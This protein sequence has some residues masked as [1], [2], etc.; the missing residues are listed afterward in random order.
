ME[1]ADR[2]HTSWALA[3]LLAAVA[4]LL[5]M[6]YGPALWTPDAV[7]FSNAGDG[8][9]NYYTFLYHAN[10]DASWW[11]FRGMNHP[12]GEHVFFTDGHPWVSGLLR[13][14][15]KIFPGIAGHGVGILNYVLLLGILACAL[16][17][18]LLMRKFDVRPWLAAVGA[19]GITVLAPQTPRLLGHMALSYSIFLP[20]TWYVLIQVIHHKRW[21]RWALFLF[22]TQVLWWSTHAYLGAMA[23]AFG[24]LFA[25]V[26]LIIGRGSVELRSR[27][28]VALCACVLPILLFRT[29][30]SITDHHVGRSEHPSGFFQY[31]AE[32]DDILLPSNP[33]LRPVLD[34]FTDGTISTQWEA[35]AYIGIGTILVLILWVV[36]AIRRKRA[37]HP[38]QRSPIAM[39]AALWSSLILLLFAFCIPFKD[40]PG[41]LRWFPVFE[42]FRATGRFTWP[43]FFVITVC[44]MY[45]INAW[46]RQERWTGSRAVAV[47]LGLCV[48]VTWVMEGLPAHQFR[49][50]LENSPNLFSTEHA[51]AELVA[52]V[53]SQQ[54]QPYQALLPMPYFNF[55]SESFTRPS[56]DGITRA[57][58]PI[59]Y[60]LHLPI[61]GS[62]LSRVSVPESKSL[63][64]I[65]SAPWY[66]KPIADQLTRDREI[67]IVRSD[68]PLTANEAA[69][70]ALARPVDSIPGIRLYAIHPDELF[71]VRSDEVLRAFQGIRRSLVEKNGL[72]VSDSNATAILVDFEDRPS[73][74]A[75]RGSGAFT[76]NKLGVN[77]VAEIEL[78]GVRLGEEMELSAWMYN[79][80]PE[81]LNLGLRL[82]V[83]QIDPSGT[84]NHVDSTLPNEAETVDGDWSLVIM[85]FRTLSD[86]PQIHV[87]TVCLG[88]HERDLILDDLLIRVPKGS[89]YRVLEGSADDPSKLFYN[90]HVID[91]H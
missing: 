63:T 10:D 3:V 80:A 61:L 46:T 26:T 5:A 87:R 39:N 36:V 17:L 2:K 76:G 48:P 44:V 9:K 71:K 19:F 6:N 20:L 7:M 69:I 73:L 60:H 50:T 31:T 8:L 55:G 88:Y 37:K 4:V 41:L 13:L 75:H 24:A 49:T 86:D 72:L 67:L 33:P 38:L 79:G 52:L 11:E 32:P 22:A 12:Y 25:L 84:G 58:L 57:A 45:L 15:G 1:S 35:Q 47:L 42:Q 70:I 59:S 27:S 82:E 54:G 51:P 74:K 34:H 64:Q 56:L 18:F 83:V 66:H 14:L 78:R 23:S 81:S 29:V 90:N 30:V 91:R 43:F 40:L 21:I 53:R 68:E 89:V 77:T 65:V 16:V 28:I 62:I 85:R